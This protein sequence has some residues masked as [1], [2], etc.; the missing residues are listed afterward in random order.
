MKNH[1]CTRLEPASLTEGKESAAIT[2]GCGFIGLR[3]LYRL[4]DK[5]RY[6]RR[7][8]IHNLSIGIKEQNAVELIQNDILIRAGPG[9]LPQS[10][11]RSGSERSRVS[12]QVFSG[13]GMCLRT[14]LITTWP[15]GR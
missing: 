6:A 1:G 9:L 8:I 7:L 3:R 5:G 13:T 4:L 14:N 10:T 12:F 15:M 2:G 11:K